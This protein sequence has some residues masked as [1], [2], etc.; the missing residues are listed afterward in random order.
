MLIRETV[1]KVKFRSEIIIG[2]NLTKRIENLINK[3]L[4]PCQMGQASFWEEGGRLRTK[5][6][7]S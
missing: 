2:H 4:Q 1:Y 3:E 5:S 6:I 7:W